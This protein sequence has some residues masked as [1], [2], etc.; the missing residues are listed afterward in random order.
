MSDEQ[1]VRNDYHTT[2]FKKNLSH[3]SIYRK[4]I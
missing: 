3:G 2:Y 4:R 1:L